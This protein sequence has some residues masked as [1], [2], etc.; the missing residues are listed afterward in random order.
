[1][2][3]DASGRLTGFGLPTD[4]LEGVIDL[5]LPFMTSGCPGRTMENACNRPFANDTPSQAEEGL[6]RNFPFPPDAV[7]VTRIRAQLWR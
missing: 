7:D 5:G 1:M 6:M 3:F 4:K 2:T